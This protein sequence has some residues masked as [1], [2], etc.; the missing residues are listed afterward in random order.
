MDE[1]G[2]TGLVADLLLISALVFGVYY[3]R[4]RRRHMVVPYVGLNVGVYAVVTALLGADVGMGVGIGLFGVLSIIRLRSAEISHG[5]VCYYFSSLAIGLVCGMT[6]AS[7][8]TGPLLGLLVVV[9]MAVID[10]PF[11]HRRWRHERVVLERVFH[12]RTELEARLF[13]LLDAEA[14]VR[15]ETV[16][17]DLVRDSQTVEVTYRVAAASVRAPVLAR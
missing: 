9:V 11:L 3:R 12:S 14:I 13:E 1:F 4:H 5:D 16:E 15:I 10:Q 7:P 2:L 17:T 8:W 6:L